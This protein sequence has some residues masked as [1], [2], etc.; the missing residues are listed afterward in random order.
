MKRIPMALHDV[1]IVGAGV[2]G[3]S[4]A[5]A[6]ARTGL[7]ILVL[8]KE[9]DAGFC[10][11]SSN[12]GVVHSGIH[13]APGSNRARFNVAG[14]QLMEPLCR[15]LHVP[16]KRTGKLTVAWNTQQAAKLI[17]LYEQGRANGVPDMNIIDR[18]AMEILQPGISGIQA[19]YTPTTGIVSPYEL[20]I[21]LAE[22]AY[23][24]GVVFSFCSRLSGIKPPDSSSPHFQL[25]VNEKETASNSNFSRPDAESKLQAKVVINAAGLG[26]A[27]VARMAGIETP[28]IFPCRGEY[29][30]LDKRLRDSLNLLIYPVPGA[31]SGGLGIHLTNTTEGVILIGPSN[32]YIKDSEDTATTAEILRALRNEGHHLLPSL[33]TNDFIR[34]FS[35]IRP[36][37][38]PP[39]EG[40][41]RDFII[42]SSSEVPG[43]IHLT[44]IESP[45]L[46]AS[47]AIA[48]Q[49][50]E[51]VGKLLPLG[52]RE[53]FITGRPPINGTPFLSTR[54][55]NAGA[56]EKAEMTARDPDYGSIVCR[57]ETVPLAEIKNAVLR[58]FG[59]ITLAGIKYRTR[60]MM[61]RCQGGF[62]L[63][64]IS[65]ILEKHF[66]LPPE[67]Q[68]LKGPG[69]ELFTGRLR[70][71]DPIGETNPPQTNREPSE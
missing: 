25:T 70:P 4:I 23:A 43:F 37:L 66:D 35:G 5:A 54:F 1:V 61:G 36:K 48:E 51:M 40:G 13:Y 49:V 71:L 56:G 39:E 46:T 57:C 27:E 19:L 24:N 67:Q 31:H 55:A 6:L 52:K 29:Y 30:I 32:E 69:S 10:T 63:Q 60:A 65:E 42:E 16:F 9:A 33:D 22:R 68:T 17:S 50:K 41:F 7:S 45:G 21:A 12:S 20:T 58:I 59:P 64:R 14:N 38:A 47:P 3:C 44:G 34:S 28:E 2:I 11:S 53:N 26:S 15:E 62:C 18:D 8:E